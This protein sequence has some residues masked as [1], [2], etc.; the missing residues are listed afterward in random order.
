MDHRFRSGLHQRHFI[1]TNTED[2]SVDTIRLV[3]PI[4]RFGI[5]QGQISNDDDAYP[6]K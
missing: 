1:S 5:F 2:I 3:A 4:N 6:A